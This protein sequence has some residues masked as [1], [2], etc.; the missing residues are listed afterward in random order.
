MANLLDLMSEKDRAKALERF[1]KRTEDTEIGVKVTPSIY[2]TAEFGYY[3]GWEGV[4]AIR[5]NEIQLEEV[6]ALLEG[7]RKVW[8]HKLVE[9]S[10]AMTTAV[11]TPL[12]G[13]RANKTYKDGMKYFIERSKLDG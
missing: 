11:A 3:F 13:K 9:Q 6:H 8:Y 1:R 2:L 10:K 5:K 4:E 7:A 12:A